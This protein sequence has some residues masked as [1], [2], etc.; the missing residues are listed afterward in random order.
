MSENALDRTARALDLIPFILE[1]PGLTIEELAKEFETTP[2]EITKDLNLL[3]VCG[4]PGYTPLELIDLSFESGS[5][6]VIEPQ[7]LDRPRKLNRREVISLILALEGL[8]TLRSDGD[9]LRLEILKL[10]DSLVATIKDANLQLATH[11]EFLPPSPFLQIIEGAISGRSDLNLEYL[12]G[13]RDER[14]ER[15]VTPAQL[16]TEN[17]FIY[18]IGYCFKSEAD[19]TFRLDR[20]V[21]C[22]RATELV[23]TSETSTSSTQFNSDHN[24][25]EEPILEISH[26]ARNFLEENAAVLTILSTNPDF[27]LAQIAVLD[28]EWLI[29]SVL[30]LGG[31]VTVRSPATL[32]SQIHQRAQETLDRY[33]SRLR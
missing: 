21:K 6:S 27:T 18:L 4:L 31:A 23:A 14:S 24:L 1:N 11:E 17:G 3:F 10:R 33:N 32:R 9:K 25:T 22:E 7:S 2:K 12:S 15:R 16:Y 13:N 20:I 5:V 28:P 19:R 30:G 8:A 26:R 29:R